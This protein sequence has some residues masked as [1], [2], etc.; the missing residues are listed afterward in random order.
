M[1]QLETAGAEWRRHW[2]MVL[3]ACIGFSFMS[4]MTAAAGVFMDPLA[5][6]FHWGRTELSAGMAIASL[7][8]I[9]CSPFIGILIDRHG[10]RRLALPGLVLTSLAIAAFSQVNGSIPQWLALWV[11]WG[12]VALLVQSTLWSA[13]IA[14]VFRVGRGLALGVT[15]SGTALAQVV[16]P[17]LSNALIEAFGWRTAYIALGLGWGGLALVLSALFLF[18]VRDQARRRQS[19]AKGPPEAAPDLPGLGIGEAWRDISLWK[20]AVATFLVLTVTIAVVVHQFPILVEAGM[21]RSQAAWL[22]SLSG[23]AGV[24]GKLVSGT[25][26]DRF[27][28]RTVGG[29]TLA[30]TA[31]GWPL[32]MQGIATPVTI[33]IGIMISGYAAGTKIQ[34]CSYLTARYAGMRHYGTIFGFMTSVIALASAIG[35]LAAGLSY[36]RYGSY[37]PLLL[38]GV[39]ISLISGG[40]VFSLRP[41][42]EW[43]AA[44]AAPA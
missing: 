36:D 28:A 43:R 34:L 14:S 39:A 6:E 1:E 5:A 24:M 17:P 27:H 8:S 44:T 15:M 37:T 30:S 29:I 18:D 26:I 33:V 31:V 12:V 16:A 38:A 20:V 22:V 23:V 41:Y 10:S 25:L 7:L 19:Q 32:L 13:A 2:P 42:P 9:L 3:A 40:L 4:F 11:I 35:P 21:S